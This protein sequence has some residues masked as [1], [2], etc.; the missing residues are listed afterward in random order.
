[1]THIRKFNS[2]AIL[3]L[4][5]LLFKLCFNTVEEV[6]ILLATSFYKNFVIRKEGQN[7]VDFEEVRISQQ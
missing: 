3:L 5:D 7:G 4:I 1:M 6:R 2:K